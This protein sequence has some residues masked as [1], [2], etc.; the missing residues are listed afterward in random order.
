MK[1]VPRLGDSMLE[2]WDGY[3][4]RRAHR[5]SEA[6]A[7]I[8]ERVTLQQL[9]AR[10]SE[11]E[12]L[13]AAFGV[14]LTAAA[15]SALAAKRRMLGVVIA[16]AVLDDAMID[17]ATLR[18]AALSQIDSPHVRC[19]EDIH[20]VQ[21]AVETSGERPPAGRGAEREINQRI[22]EVAGKYPTPV[23]HTLATVGLLDARTT[24]DGEFNVVHGLTNFG[25]AVLQ[26][27][28]ECAEQIDQTAM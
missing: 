17:E 4:K 5:A 6:V 23:L 10:L 20:R 16:R 12:D 13:D 9:E 3:Q 8:G 21:K 22:L 11:S 19:L 28:H 15:N 18:T 1:A 24:W 27:L 7:A 26:D 25:Q 2:I 14:A